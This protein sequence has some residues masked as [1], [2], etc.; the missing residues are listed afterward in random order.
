MSQVLIIILGNVIVQLI[1]NKV[2]VYTTKMDTK[3][4]VI[5][6]ERK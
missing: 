4:K 3:D 2:I 5:N 6:Q 1:R